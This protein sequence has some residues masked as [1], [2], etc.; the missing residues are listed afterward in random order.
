MG[1]KVLYHSLA[2][3]TKIMKGLSTSAAGALVADES[4]AGQADAT[5]PATDL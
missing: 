3:Q 2:S 5:A 4:D 1:L